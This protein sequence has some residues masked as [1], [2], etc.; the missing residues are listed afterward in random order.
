VTDTWGTWSDVVTTGLASGAPATSTPHFDNSSD[1]DNPSTDTDT[2]NPSTDTD[3]PSTQ[4]DNPSTD[5]DNPSTHT[6][7]DGTR[8]RWGRVLIDPPIWCSDVYSGSRSS[9]PPRNNL[10]SETVGC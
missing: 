10:P 6:D 3:N 8:F 9:L 5:T 4:T 1:A 7:Y 2:D